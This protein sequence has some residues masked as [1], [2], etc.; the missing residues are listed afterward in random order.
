M[1]PFLVTDTPEK[2]RYQ[3]S[4]SRTRVA[5]ERTFGQLKRRFHILHSEV[6][7]ALFSKF[8]H[9]YMKYMNIDICQLI[10]LKYWNAIKKKKYR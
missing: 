8:R 7:K 6:C 3:L 9:D 10:K 4:H 1:T 2:M 5:I